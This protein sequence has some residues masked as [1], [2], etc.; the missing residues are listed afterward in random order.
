MNTS[1]ETLNSFLW[2]SNP[3]KSPDHQVQ[4]AN[5]KHNKKNKKALRSIF[6]KF[7]ARVSFNALWFLDWIQQNIELFSVTW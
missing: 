2:N 4:N 1:I 6:P 5:L 7:F 3:W